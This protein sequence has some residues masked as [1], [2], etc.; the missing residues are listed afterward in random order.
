MLFIFR[1]AAAEPVSNTLERHKP[2]FRWNV[3]IVYFD[4]LTMS[5]LGACNVLIARTQSP[6]WQNDRIFYFFGLRVILVG[7]HGQARH[8]QEIGGDLGLTTALDSIFPET[9]G[10]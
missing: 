2:G 7:Q 1:S 9:S 6:L 10:F 4:D 3:V 5:E 8:C